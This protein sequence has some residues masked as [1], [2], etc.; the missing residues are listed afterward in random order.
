MKEGY[1]FMRCY[2]KLASMA[3]TLRKPL[4]PYRPK[5]HVLHHFIADMDQACRKNAAALNVLAFSCSA[6]EDFIGRTALLSRRVASGN[7]HNRVLQR[8][9]AGA[10]Q[11]WSQG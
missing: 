7:A 10:M 2:R 1:K 9:L 8:W 3:F 4:W 5:I 11:Q 6:S